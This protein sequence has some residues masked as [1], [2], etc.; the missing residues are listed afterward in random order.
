MHVDRSKTMCA[1]LVAIFNA[2]FPSN[3]QF[4][5]A[6]KSNARENKDCF[7]TPKPICSTVCRRTHGLRSSRF[8]LPNIFIGCL[9][10]Y[11]SVGSSRR[12]AFQPT[13]HVDRQLEAAVRTC[14]SQSEDMKPAAMCTLSCAMALITPNFISAKRSTCF[15]D[16]KDRPSSPTP[17]RPLTSISR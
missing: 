1:S 8:A 6:T 11:I 7:A 2:E 3:L 13:F 17:E 14:P 10:R 9:L 16:V 5:G 15:V 12:L 4:W